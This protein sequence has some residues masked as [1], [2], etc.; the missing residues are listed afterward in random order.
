MDSITHA[1]LEQMIQKHHTHCS[2]AKNTLI[3]KKVLI[4]EGR[5]VGMYIHIS[6]WQT[7]NN[8]FCKTFAKPAM[9]TLSDFSNSPK[10]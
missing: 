1:Q 10:K 4:Q 3:R 5:R 7:K 9:K 2:T 8:G 6:E